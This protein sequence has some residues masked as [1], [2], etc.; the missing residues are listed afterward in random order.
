MHKIKNL[1]A[2]TLNKELL[3]EFL[4]FV[5]EELKINKPYSLYFVEDKTNAKD[6]L[7]RTAMYNPSSSSV[8][9]YATNRHPKDILRSIAHE[10][11]HHKQH[12]DGRLEDMSFEKSEKEANAGGF[13]VRQ[14][15]DGRELSTNKK[16]NEARGKYDK[17]LPHQNKYGLYCLPKG[18]N[19]ARSILGGSDWTVEDVEAAR[20]DLW[21]K[22]GNRVGENF[23]MFKSKRESVFERLKDPMLRK[24]VLEPYFFPLILVKIEAFKKASA[25]PD[26]QNNENFKSYFDE[27]SKTITDPANIQ[28]WDRLLL[29]FAGAKGF[30]KIDEDVLQRLSDLK[31]QGA[32][33]SVKGAV[34][35]PGKVAQTDAP[36]DTK[37][38]WQQILDKQKASKNLKEQV[39]TKNPLEAFEIYSKEAT[40]G[41]YLIDRLFIEKPVLRTDVIDDEVYSVSPAMRQSLINLAKTEDQSNKQVGEKASAI[42]G[43][44]PFSEKSKRAINAL[45]SKRERNIVVALSMLGAIPLPPFWLADVILATYYLNKGYEKYDR[46]GELPRQE[47]FDALLAG[48]MAF[49]FSG[50]KG[51]IAALSN[52]LIGGTR[53]LERTKSIPAYLKALKT[54]DSSLAQSER[55]IRN[56]RVAAL[57]APK[58]VVN[59]ITGRLGKGDETAKAVQDVLDKY[60]GSVTQGLRTIADKRNAVKREIEIFSEVSSILRRGQPETVS[61]AFGAATKVVDDAYKTFQKFLERPGGRLRT[62]VRQ[63]FKKIMATL[64]ESDP[65]LYGRIKSGFGGDTESAINALTKHYAKKLVKAQKAAKR[66]NSQFNNAIGAYSKK[67]AGKSI[68]SAIDVQQARKTIGADLTSNKPIQEIAQDVV[69][70]QQKL[71]AEGAA[72]RVSGALNKDLERAVAGEGGELTEILTDFEKIGLDTFSKDVFSNLGSGFAT[73]GQKVAGVVARLGTRFSVRGTGVFERA[74]KQ[75]LTGG[76]YF[77]S[78]YKAAEKISFNLATRLGRKFPPFAKPFLVAQHLT[79][80]AFFAAYKLSVPSMFYLRFYR[81]ICN[82]SFSEFMKAVEVNGYASILDPFAGVANLISGS[83]EDYIKGV[84]KRGY[85]FFDSRTTLTKTLCK[86]VIEAQDK[87]LKYKK[88]VEKQLRNAVLETDAAV[89]KIANSIKNNPQLNK[90]RNESL[91]A[92]EELEKLAVLAKKDPKAAAEQ[93]KRFKEKVSPDI[94]KALDGVLTDELKKSIKEIEKAGKK[95]ATNAIKDFDSF[96]KKPEN[97]DHFTCV[98]TGV[99]KSPEDAERERLGKIAVPENKTVSLSDYREKLLEERLEKL[100]IGLIK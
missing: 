99:V 59:K 19:P 67:Q 70:S 30:P 47:L 9:I 40:D 26:Y 3:E 49:G 43:V 81:P 17:C 86:G 13:L 63:N 89:N 1:A 53:I 10:L 79:K 22:T 66:A 29:K 23:D 45:D 61:A 8:Y 91:K 94:Q 25:P 51:D 20:K 36:A 39:K 96:C 31:K 37:N 64:E 55:L 68:D 56:T 100:T 57:G 95:M 7:G 42:Y 28:F 15:E 32:T 78:A 93:L 50:A 16:I 69:N 82:V 75:Y 62:Y 72:N 5:N 90:T 77:K 65:K 33:A 76:G 88:F 12:C 80:I 74:I 27:L 38:I 14:F 58:A 6:A 24:M 73:V 85:K 4:N 97:R 46:T 87:D 18:F 83:T 98:K 54:V 60:D 35:L 84:R 2:K 44:S 41:A 71:G 92:L 34:G 48:A 11:V 52:K 21:V